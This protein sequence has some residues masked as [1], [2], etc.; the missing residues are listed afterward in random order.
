MFEKKTEG[1]PKS[2]SRRNRMSAFLVGLGRPKSACGRFLCFRPF[3]RR[4]HNTNSDQ[5]SQQTPNK[6]DTNKDRIEHQA[7]T[8]MTIQDN[9]KSIKG[10]DDEIT[11]ALKAILDNDDNDKTPTTTQ[12][13]AS[14]D[15]MALIMEPEKTKN[16]TMNDQNPTINDEN[17]T[18]SP[19]KDR[20]KNGLELVPMATNANETGKESPIIINIDMTDVPSTDD[21]RYRTPV[22]TNKQKRKRPTDNNKESSSSKK[23]R[24]ELLTKDL[25]QLKV[26]RINEHTKR[27]GENLC[28]I[29][30]A[31]TGKDTWIKLEQAVKYPDALSKYLE[32]LM[33]HRNRSYKDLERK[34]QYLFEAVKK[35][36]GNK[37]VIKKEE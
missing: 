36:L 16:D 34:H 19:T 7:P 4:L 15:P 22:T 24:P 21:E 37:V 18:A 17:N 3:G 6:K 32:Y 13:D 31:E 11:M 33:V 27:R 12:V 9:N 5:S 29:T 30:W 10:D 2:A 26:A 20:T 28:K 1:R 25:V 8:N 35:H 23:A 14:F